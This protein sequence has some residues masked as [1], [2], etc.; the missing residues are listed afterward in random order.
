MTCVTYSK[1]VLLTDTQTTQY[2]TATERKIAFDALLASGNQEYIDT[3]NLM[4]THPNWDKDNYIFSY[5]NGK[6]IKCNNNK[7]I[8][9]GHQVK[10][11][12]Y[13]GNGDLVAHIDKYAHEAND[14]NEFIH[15][16]NQYVHAQIGEIKKVHGIEVTPELIA[17]VDVAL[18]LVTDAGA[19]VILGSYLEP[20]DW[21]WHA[22]D[23]EGVVG[24]GS[25]FC[26][27][28]GLD[29]I[30]ENEGDV[31]TCCFINNME[32]SRIHLNASNLDPMTNNVLVELRV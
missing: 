16:I 13:A 17:K 1:G 3:F 5:E 23:A 21:Y 27:V 18:M 15:L 30:E 19:M 29:V 6:F 32:Q 10:A 28:V 7:L 25:G 4:S 14:V 20:D 26:Q 2:Q 8:V 11:I 31:K 12:A 22:K 9:N 24:I